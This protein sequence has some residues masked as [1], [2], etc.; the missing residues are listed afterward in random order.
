M[1]LAPFPEG[2]L[3]AHTWHVSDDSPHGH[4]KEQT[5]ADAGLNGGQGSESRCR[6]ANPAQRDTEFEP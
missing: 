6:D 2:Y 4:V 3:A 1:L 5:V